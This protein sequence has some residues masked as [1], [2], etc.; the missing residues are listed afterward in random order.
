MISIFSLV[1]DTPVF[2]KDHQTRLLPLVA[3]SKE[4]AEKRKRPKA[5]WK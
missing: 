1:Q 2:T 4:L 3:T 5:F